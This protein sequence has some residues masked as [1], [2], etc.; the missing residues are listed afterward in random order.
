MPGLATRCAVTVGRAPAPG[1][2]A[3]PDLRIAD[4]FPLELAPPTLQPSKFVGPA[5]APRLT[6]PDTGAFD[7]NLKLPT[8]HE[9]NLN[10]QKQLPYGM[11]A[12][13]GY[14][15]KRGL[16]LLRAYDLNQAKTDHDGLLDS[17]MLAQANLAKGC[18]PDGT[19]CPAGITGQP[20]G[21]LN[22]I[23][24]GTSGINS[25]TSI[26][27]L[28]RNAFANL[29]QRVDQ[30]DIVAKGFPAN[31]FRPNPQFSQIFYI[32]SGGNSYYHALQVQ[33]RRQ[34][35]KGLTYGLAYTLGKSIDDMSVDPVG[36]SS[37]GGLSTTNSRTP[38]DI[39]NWRLDRSR[40]DFDNRH[41]LVTYALWDIPVGK[42][43]F[44]K[45]LNCLRPRGYEVLFGQSSGPVPPLDPQVLNQKGSLFLTRPTLAHYT[46]TRQ[47]LLDRAN[48]L[49]N[50][51]AAGKL[52]V[53]IGRTYPLDQ[54]AAAQEALRG[55]QTTGKVVL[56]P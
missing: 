29:L 38:T 53:R 55:R 27:D 6:A 24:P 52:K 20:I 37:G 30:T 21:I 10:I 42:D 12:Q 50:W 34:F 41:V 56:I 28:Q 47:E 43:V 31:F 11:V 48:D 25:S 2:S 17:F 35:E 32:D 45:N 51:I 22:T 40:S 8:V 23:F 7:P 39:R 18:R 9:W 4:N 1:C 15:G 44:D 14:I 26:T 16:R 19:G 33:L 49:F 54:A 5:P 36:A 3:V 13:V 46:R